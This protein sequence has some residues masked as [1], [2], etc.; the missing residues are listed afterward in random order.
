MKKKKYN[1]ETK[2][3]KKKKKNQEKKKKN[4]KKRLGYSLSVKIVY[5]VQSNLAKYTATKNDRSE[6]FCKMI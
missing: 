5:V 4:K 6:S 1:S 2:K 3:K